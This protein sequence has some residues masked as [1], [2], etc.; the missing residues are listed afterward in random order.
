M[1]HWPRRC[2]AAIAKGDA[3]ASVGNSHESARRWQPGWRA[4]AG[5]S[6]ATR[7]ETQSFGTLGFVVLSCRAC[8]LQSRNHE[9]SRAAAEKETK[10]QFSQLEHFEAHCSKDVAG[11]KPLSVAS[12]EPADRVMPQKPGSGE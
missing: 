2:A 12:Q 5:G 9:H 4:G 7:D 10:R 1:K 8:N 11:Q 6:L 3:A